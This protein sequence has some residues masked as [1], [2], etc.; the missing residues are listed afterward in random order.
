MSGGGPT[1]KR[2]Q[3]LQPDLLEP[4]ALKGARTVLRGRG[5]GDTASLP[6]KLGSDLALAIAGYGSGIRGALGQPRL[7]IDFWVEITKKS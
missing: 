1:R 2:E 5:S 4:C 3:K 7:I 6:N